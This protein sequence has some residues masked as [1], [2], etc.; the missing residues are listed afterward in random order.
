MTCNRRA[1]FPRTNARLSYRALLFG[2]AHGGVLSAREL[3]YA[4]DLSGK[5]VGVGLGTNYEQW[6]RANVPGADVRTYDDDPTKFA[7]LNNGRTDAILIDHRLHAD[8]TSGWIPSAVRA[9]TPPI[10]S[11]ISWR[12]RISRS[13]P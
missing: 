7:D 6:V 11:T 1:L 4:A 8:N 2:L 9:F 12:M 5:K 10:P 3:A 13:P